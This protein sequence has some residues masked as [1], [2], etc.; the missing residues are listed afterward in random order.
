MSIQINKVGIRVTEQWAEKEIFLRAV[1]VS[2]VH[3]VSYGLKPTLSDNYIFLW[4]LTL[5]FA[6]MVQNVFWSIW[7]YS[8][9]GC[10]WGVHQAMLPTSLLKP[11]YGQAHFTVL[12][13][14]GEVSHSHVAIPHSGY[15]AHNKSTWLGGW[16]GL[17]SYIAGK[18]RGKTEPFWYRGNIPSAYPPGEQF[19]TG[20][21]VR[22]Y[23]ANLPLWAT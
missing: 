21:P 19:T 9:A 17:I 5:V 2:L 1:W 15:F 22:T 23:R 13:S 10:C 16:S 11:T 6:H 4:L 18:Q 20:C 7:V 14:E 12:R 8:L 3:T